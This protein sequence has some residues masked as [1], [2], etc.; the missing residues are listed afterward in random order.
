MRHFDQV[1]YILGM[2]AGF[3]AFEIS[4]FHY[5]SRIKKVKLKPKNKDLL[6]NSQQT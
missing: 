6:A 2:Q 4:I 1:R 5:F 3:L